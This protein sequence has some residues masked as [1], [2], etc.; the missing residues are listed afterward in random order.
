MTLT[1]HAGGVDVAERWTATLKLP[2]HPDAGP[3]PREAELVFTNVD[4][5]AQRRFV[6]EPTGRRGFYRA[7]VALPAP[8]TWT[9]YV[10]AREIGAVSP[11]PRTNEVVVRPAVSADRPS[12]GSLLAAAVGV[13]G[14]A[15][16]L[17]L[18]AK[19]RR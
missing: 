3:L 1:G 11:G 5:Y 4:T 16:V 10:Y 6:A 19:R 7:S 2:T 18:R 15:L 14:I 9:I 8:G 17:R 12:L 13:S